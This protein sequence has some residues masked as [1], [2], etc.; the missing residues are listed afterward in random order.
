MTATIGIE[1]DDND[2]RFYQVTAD[3]KGYRINQL[4][5]I[6]DNSKLVLEYLNYRYS[7]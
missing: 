3:L 2:K 7:L 1:V 5:S 6:E 4:K